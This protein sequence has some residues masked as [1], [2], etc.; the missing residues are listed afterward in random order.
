VSVDE[1]FDI[2]SDDATMESPAA[3][4]NNSIPKAKSSFDVKS[5]IDSIK[6][7]GAK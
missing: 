4:E 7:A 1:A 3:I 2:F 6:T 5:Y